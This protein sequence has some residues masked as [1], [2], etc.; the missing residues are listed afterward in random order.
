[1]FSTKFAIVALFITLIF[2][3]SACTPLNRPPVITLGSGPIVPSN[4]SREIS[5]TVSDPEGDALTCTWSAQ[6]GKVPS[7]PQPCSKIEYIAPPETGSDKI[8][9]NVDDGNGNV[10]PGHLQVS[11]VEPQTPIVTIAPLTDT[12][13]TPTPTATIG[14]PTDTQ[15]PSP[16]P[17][18]PSPSPIALSFE[19]E[20]CTMVS[21]TPIP[22]PTPFPINTMIKCAGT[23]SSPLEIDSANVR[24][25]IVLRDVIGN[26]YHQNPP[27]DLRPDGNWRAPNVKPGQ[28]I[29]EILAVRVN[30]EGHEFFLDLVKKGDF[31]GLLQ[32]PGGSEVLDSVDIT[33]Q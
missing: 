4:E 33:T 25:W 14:P 28:D 13:D 27:V 19:I 3:T 2:L 30:Q 9:V 18:T 7:G 32:L 5:I 6:R 1:M 31:S 16:T 17:N 29:T 15:T 26:Y 20:V 10:V 24:I 21:G 22:T 11:V 12:T 8:T 23:Y